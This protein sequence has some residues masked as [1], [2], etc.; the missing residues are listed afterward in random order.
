MNQAG[1]PKKVLDL[2]L[3]YKDNETD[4]FRIE[5]RRERAMA[6]KK[7]LAEPERLNLNTFNQEVWR[8]G[9]ELYLDGE[10]YKASFIWHGDMEQPELERFRSALG[11]GRLIIHGNS[12][13]GS[14]THVFAPG[15]K[16]EEKKLRSI[17]TAA[18]ILNDSAIAPLD[19]AN[20][21]KKLPGFGYNSATGLVMVFH[22]YE[23]AIYNKPSIK[24][25][26]LIGLKTENIEDFQEAVSWLKDHTGATDFLELDLFLYYLS[27]GK[28]RIDES[29]GIRERIKALLSYHCPPERLEHR[30]RSELEARAMLEAKGG[31]FDQDDLK[32]FLSKADSDYWNGK[33]IKARWGLAFIATN[34]EKLVS[35][36]ETVNAWIGR[37]WTA[38]ADEV[39]DTLD[40][41]F[42]TK[43]IKGAAAALPS[44]VLY[45][46]D[47][48]KF[49]VMV[50]KM[51][52]AVA[53]LA[54]YTAK[55]PS[56]E[57]YYDYNHEVMTFKAAHE[58]RSQELDII[59]SL[60]I[61]GPPLPPKY[62][63][64]DFVTETGFASEQIEGWR[65]RLKRKKQAI[66]QGPP[67]TGKTFVAKRLAKLL[68]GGEEKNIAFIQF[69][70]S[71]SYEDFMQGLRPVSSGQGMAFE[72]VKGRFLDF[73]EH[74]ALGPQE[75]FVLIIDEI[76]R[77][78]L[79][80][81][82]GEAMSLLEYRDQSIPLASGGSPFSIPA[83]IYLIG[84]MNTADRSIALIDH[85]LRRRFSFI[86][87]SPEYHILKDYLDKYGL[88]S[89]SLIDVLKRLNETIG[90]PNYHLGISYFMQD[91]EELRQ[92]I[93]EIWESEIEPYLE[94]Y[95]YDMPTKMEA[96]RWEK[97]VGND[98]REWSQ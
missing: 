8:L 51:A 48:D 59:L 10:K 26:S 91:K 6:L 84:T 92:T 18:E 89:D 64:E 4:K 45:L 50:P 54:G 34:A 80:R 69:H 37:L 73:C 55:A 7:L 78:N 2:Y 42:I 63:I 17:R 65:S 93:R 43:P 32:S 86:R 96:F 58:L 47:P 87:L 35:Q 60:G 13:W 53:R 28:I 62:G 66:F 27:E 12:M 70:P 72:L 16:D 95:F 39:M 11:T 44:L 31:R 25:L 77:A 19:K 30:R 14:A 97:L 71:Y 29:D 3:E 23:F 36:L 15:I 76:N 52:A 57:A 83:N 21:I 98:L 33:K 1:V 75:P 22:P 20:K 40:E 49:N 74:A 24:A 67:G 5:L 68:T 56:A 41:Y 46:K 79:S 85:A 90:D 38:A 9:S 81:V 88:P 82:F 94:E 61:N